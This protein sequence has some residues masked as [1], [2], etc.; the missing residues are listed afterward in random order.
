MVF[1]LTKTIEQAG[2]AEAIKRVFRR[3]VLLFVIGSST[4]GGLTNPGRTSG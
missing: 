2:R 3:G 1:S 4:P